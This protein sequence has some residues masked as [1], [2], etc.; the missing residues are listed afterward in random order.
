MVS[1]VHPRTLM[2][3]GTGFT[4]FDTQGRPWRI[5]L[6]GDFL[7][8]SLPGGARQRLCGGIKGHCPRVPNRG[9]NNVRAYSLWSTRLPRASR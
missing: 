1:A 4:N 3:D 2:Q 5:S 7:R 9:G 6:A 8:P